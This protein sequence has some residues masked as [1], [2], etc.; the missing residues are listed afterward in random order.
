M[1]FQ[2]KEKGQQVELCQV[3]RFFDVDDDGFIM[4]EDLKRVMCVIGESLL[5]KELKDMFIKVDINKDSFVDMKGKVCN[6]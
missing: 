2:I 6:F 3:F 5:E 4:F 1:M